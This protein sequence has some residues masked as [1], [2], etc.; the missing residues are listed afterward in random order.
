MST[1][2]LDARNVINSYADYEWLRM[3]VN[4]KKMVFRINEM[5]Q[6]HR[7]YEDISFFGLAFLPAN[8][9]KTQIFLSSHSHM[10][11]TIVYIQCIGN[12]MTALANS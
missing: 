2:L 12:E 10:S 5:L 7:A 9:F 4:L 3:K 8:F 11:H 1:L 6:C